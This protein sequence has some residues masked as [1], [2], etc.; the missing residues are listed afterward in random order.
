MGRRCSPGPCYLLMDARGAHCNNVRR[1]I[2]RYA[3]RYL[4]LRSVNRPSHVLVQ[5]NAVIARPSMRDIYLSYFSGADDE[6]TRDGKL[7]ES[8]RVSLFFFL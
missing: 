4:R 2:P 6:N 8:F 5:S 3:T 7:G 1:K